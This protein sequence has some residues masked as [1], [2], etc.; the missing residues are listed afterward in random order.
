MASTFHCFEM[1]FCQCLRTIVLF[2]FSGLPK[3]TGKKVFLALVNLLI[4]VW[5]QLKKVY[6]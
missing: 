6:I 3:M 4:K 5:V 1:L 2:L